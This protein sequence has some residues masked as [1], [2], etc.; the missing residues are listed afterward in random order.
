MVSNLKRAPNQH[1]LGIRHPQACSPQILQLSPVFERKYPNVPQ[2]DG[3]SFSKSQCLSL[4]G[5]PIG[6]WEFSLV[7]RR[8]SSPNAGPHA[9]CPVKAQPSAW[10]KPERSPCCAHLCLGGPKYQ[11]LSKFPLPHRLG[12]VCATA[13][14][15]CQFS[16][17]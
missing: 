14:P 10:L 17:T 11:S 2:R 8:S 4:W 5:P 9:P 7:A 12:M 16:A 3:I 13:V 1:N 6:Y 15:R